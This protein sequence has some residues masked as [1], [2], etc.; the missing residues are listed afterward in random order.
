MP[1]GAIRTEQYVRSEEFENR[2]AELLKRQRCGE[3]LDFEQIAEALN[4]PA[5]AAWRQ[6]RNHMTTTRPKLRS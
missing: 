6:P 4:L 5:I 1:K 2:Y 3:R